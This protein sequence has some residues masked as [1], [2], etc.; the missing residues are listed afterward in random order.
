MWKWN[1]VYRFLMGKRQG[2]IP[3]EKPRRLREDNIKSKS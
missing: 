1:V 3:L 2:K